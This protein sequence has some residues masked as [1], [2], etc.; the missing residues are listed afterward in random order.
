VLLLLATMLPLEDANALREHL[1]QRAADTKDH[2]LSDSVIRA[3]RARTQ[4]ETTGAAAPNASA[5]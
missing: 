1:L 3:V 4:N 2:N 5:A